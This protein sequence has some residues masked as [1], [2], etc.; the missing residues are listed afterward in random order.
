[1]VMTQRSRP[2]LSMLGGACALCLAVGAW[3]STPLWACPPEEQSAQ[4]ARELKA[5]KTPKPP[6]APKAPKAPRAPRAVIVQPGTPAPDDVTT[7]EEHMAGRERPGAP[8]GDDVRHRLD[9]LE[10]RLNRLSEQLDALMQGGGRGGMGGGGGGQRRSPL[11]LMVPQGEDPALT[12]PYLAAVEGLR[13]ANAPFGFAP[14]DDGPVIVRIYRLPTGKRDSF[15]QFMSRSDVPILVG[16]ADEGIE[17][18]ATP[19]QHEIV[20]AFIAIVNPSEDGQE[21]EGGARQGEWRAREEMVRAYERAAQ[22]AV[23][24]IKPVQMQEEVRAKIE[25]A[26]KHH[27]DKHHTMHEHIRKLHEKAEQLR[28]KAGELRHKSSEKH[29]QAAELEDEAA[30]EEMIAVAEALSVEADSFDE[31]ADSQQEQIDDLQAEIDELQAELEELIAEAEEAAAEA[32]AEEAEAAAEAAEAE[33]EADAE[34]AA[35]GATSEKSGCV[36]AH[37]KKSGCDG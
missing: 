15:Y 10:E 34:D 17:V 28:Q 13:A 20:A 16:V 5:A 27:A 6:K 11:T 32:D 21:I 22:A 4:A 18:H 1:M 24:R 25:A 12:A 19:R 36:E 9:R 14:A 7:F 30:R 31:Q 26:M 29:S 8:G 35:L 23:G 3:L 33:A 2:R 37:S